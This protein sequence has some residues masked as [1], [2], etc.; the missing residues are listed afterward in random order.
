MKGQTN[1][2]TNK[3]TDEPTIRRTLDMNDRIALSRL[4]QF[5]YITP[6]SFFEGAIGNVDIC[7]D[8]TDDLEIEGESNCNNW[9]KRVQHPLVESL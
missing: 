2:V 8:V 9:F 5:D 6:H 4:K 7:I 3:L 1:P